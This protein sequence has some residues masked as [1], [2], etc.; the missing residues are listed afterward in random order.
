[1]DDTRS[2]NQYYAHHLK[3]V[4]DHILVRTGDKL[5]QE[6]ALRTLVRNRMQ[7]FN[8]KQKAVLA[9]FFVTEYPHLLRPYGFRFTRKK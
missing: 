1:M 7:H 3:D 5:R 9:A 6:E 2:E 4:Q 8:K